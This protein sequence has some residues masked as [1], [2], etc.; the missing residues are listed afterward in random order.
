MRTPCGYCRLHRMQLAYHILRKRECIQ[1]GCFHFRKYEEH[2]IWDALRQA[3]EK[4]KQLRAER[5]KRL[6]EM[7]A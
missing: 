6:K 7:A 4:T 2:P 3:K 1:K 5:K